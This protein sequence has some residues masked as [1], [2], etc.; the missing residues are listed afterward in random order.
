VRLGE[1]LQP[2]QRGFNPFGGRRLGQ[3]SEG[4]MASPCWRSSSQVM[5]CTG[6]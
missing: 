5:I 4:A 1:F 6:M 3:I 2:E